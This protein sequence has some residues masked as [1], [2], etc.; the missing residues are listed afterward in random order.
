MNPDFASYLQ[1]I[2]V[3]DPIAQRI[4]TIYRFYDGLCHEEIN[5][6]FVTDYITEDGTREYENLW[7]F[8]EKFV[9]EAKMFLTGDNFDMT[10][11]GGRI[12]HWTVEKQEYDLGSAGEKSRMTLQFEIEPGLGFAGSLKAAREN[13]GYLMQI[14][15]R[16]IVKN[17][18]GRADES[19]NL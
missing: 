9:M 5:G 10:P 11:I 15:T 18:A 13:C 2:G 16:Y 6:I 7:F 19:G 1:A 4:E 12:Y 14:L 3:T 8:S 17:V